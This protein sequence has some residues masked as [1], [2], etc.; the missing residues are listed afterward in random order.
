MPS[1]AGLY[2]T[3]KKFLFACDRGF[4]PIINRDETEWRLEKLPATPS[5][6]D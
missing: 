6:T 4:M 3:R 2:D 5:N 1:L